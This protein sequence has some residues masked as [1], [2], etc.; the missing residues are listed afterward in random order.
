MQQNVLNGEQE[1][2]NEIE[3]LNYPYANGHNGMM[4]DWQLRNQPTGDEDDILL[5]NR[6]S[7]YDDESDESE[8]E[9]QTYSE[10]LMRAQTSPY[11][12]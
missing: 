9:Y 5:A 2:I 7:M 12:T 4:Y 6:L 8:N 3:R 10:W 1:D 11:T